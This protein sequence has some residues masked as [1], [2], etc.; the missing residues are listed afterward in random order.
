MESIPLP[1]VSIRNFRGLKT[2]DIKELSQFTLLVG[3]NGAGK[4][5]LLQAARLYADRGH[6]ATLKEILR[7][8]DETIPYDTPDGRNAFLPNLNALYYGSHPAAHAAITIAAGEPEQTLR[9]RYP[10]DPAPDEYDPEYPLMTLEFADRKRDL[11]F[12]EL[13]DPA[14]RAYPALDKTDSL[15]C[16]FL[17]QETANFEALAPLWDQ[18]ALTEDE[19][20]PRQALRLIYGPAVQRLEMIGDPTASPGNPG[21]RTIVKTADNPEPVPL[22]RLG[23]GAQRVFALALNLA[24]LPPGSL[25]LLDEAE[26]SL[27]RAQHQALW[28][29]ILQ[30]AQEKSLQILATTHSWDCLTGFVRAVQQQDA[31]AYAGLLRLEKK[32]ECTRVVDY[33]WKNLEVAARQG[34]EVR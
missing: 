11:S 17:S 5:N 23:Q 34:I 24:A 29:L 32:E 1:N 25:L 3:D 6:P 27:H 2:L 8:S 7:A 4:T 33:T 10:A 19:A 21:R 31:A 26:N 9:L 14:R 22:R 28:E 12:R 30:T 15:P 20:L 13:A 16:A 18:V